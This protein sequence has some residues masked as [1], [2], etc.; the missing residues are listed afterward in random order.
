VYLVASEEEMMVLDGARTKNM[1]LLAHHDL[2]GY[3]NGGE[4]LAIQTTSDG[5]RILYIA[6]ER[7]PKD[8]TSIDVT[9]PHNPKTV[10]QTDLPHAE[11]RSNSLALVGDLLL[12]AYQ[13]AEPGLFPTGMG[14]Y[15]IK[16]PKFPKQISF[17]DT[18]GPYSRGVHCFWFVDGRYAHLSTGAGDF[19]PHD[20]KDD[21]FYMI[22]DLID[23]ANPKEVGRWWLPGTRV[24]DSETPPDR[25]TAI[26]SGFRLHNANVYPERPDRAYLGYLD[27]GV[28]LLDVA[29]LAHPTMISRLDYHPPMP[30]FTHTVLPLFSRDLLIVTDEAVRTDCSDWPKL[31]WVMDGS[32]ESNPTIVSTL[33]MPSVEEF[34]KEGGRFGAHNIHENQPVPTSWVSDTIIVGAY[35]NAGVRVHDVSDPFR[36]EEVAFYVPPSP[37]QEH[38]LN[39]NDVYVDENR[40]V[41]AIDRWTGGLYILEM[42]I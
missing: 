41:Y 21:Q 33:P 36:P 38:G 9:D 6:H 5:R 39:I 18:S 4:G 27:G 8:F 20:Q 23:P 34:C 1:R 26:D 12:V 19:Q 2:D 14:V 7:A 42:D 10:V 3:G 17:F 29:D 11:V 13:T 40:I 15:D 35:F 25:H 37:S 30:G 31:T 32:H 24:G 28:V 22:V 16:D